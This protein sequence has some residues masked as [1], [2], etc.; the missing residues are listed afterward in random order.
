MSYVILDLEWN[1]SYSKLLH[2]FVNEIIEFGA[3][4]T[5]DEFN[6]IDTFSVLVTPKIGKKL[7]PKVKQLTKISYDELEQNGVPFMEAVNR[8]TDFARNSVIVTWSTSDVHALIENY[9]YHTG[10]FHLPFLLRYCNVQ[11]FCEACLNIND[12]SSQLGLSACAEM[13]GIDFAEDEQHRAVSDAEL[14]L[15]CLK[16]LSQKRL[17]SDF[18][19]DAGKEEFYE[20][21][22]FKTH[23]VT[24]IESSDIDKSKMYFECSDC[25]RLTKKLTSWKIHNKAFTADFSCDNCSKKFFGRISFKRKYDDVVVRKKLI[26]KK[27]KD[28]KSEIS[29]AEL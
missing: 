16:K 28:S 18:V 4:K 22:M 27:S 11:E 19:Y 6:I 14:S 17:I 13:L 21:M 1:G 29:K 9:S 5:D 8:F 24:D 2:K 15:K 3:V 7:S 26:E 20:R 12:A 10:D 23:F 25:G